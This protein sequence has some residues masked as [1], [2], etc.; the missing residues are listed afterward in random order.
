MGDFERIFPKK[1]NIDY[2]KKFFDEPSQEN[3]KLWDEI[4]K[5]DI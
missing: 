4:K 2:Y 3:L 1:D 5:F